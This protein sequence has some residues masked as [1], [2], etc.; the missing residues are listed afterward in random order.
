ML[1]GQ[2]RRAFLRAGFAST[3]LALS[4]CTTTEQSNT[5][6]NHSLTGSTTP[7]VTSSRSTATEDEATTEAEQSVYFVAPDGRSSNAGTES[8]PYGSVQ[9]ALEEAQPGDTVRLAPGEYNQGF[10]TVRSGRPGAPITIT[11]PESALHRQI[12]I[13]N[14][15]HIHLR[16]FT[17]NGLTNPDA[18]DDPASYETVL[19]HGR[20][21]PDSDAYL[22][23]IVCAPAGIGNAARPLMLFV[24][25]K[26]LEIGPLRVIGLAG[27]QH[28]LA[29]DVEGHAGEIVY[30]GQPPVA[31]EQDEYPWDEIDQTRN[32]HVHHIDN[33]AGHPHS[34][35]VNAKVGTRDVLVEYCTDAGGSHNTEPSPAASIRFESYDSTVRWCDLRN[36][37]GY[38]IHVQAANKR[39]LE[40]RDDPV[41]DPSVIGTG[42]EIYGNR[43]EGFHNHDLVFDF[44]T[45]DNQANICGNTIDAMYRRPP[46]ETERIDGSPD[47]ECSSSLPTGQGVG[48]TGGTN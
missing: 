21:P 19:V 35:I 29:D 40:D 22:E 46:I 38:A 2:R 16:G 31:Y 13:I 14:H 15:S 24:R 42:H 10:R 28:T 12:V 3:V 1:D 11:G 6:Q 27:A 41:V 26:N 43:V 36:G 8:S 30:L 37:D 39:W 18:P 34:E 45:P 23:D 25:T 48:H 20:P 17:I 9:R 32:V 4:G 7:P 47:K 44:T 5:P 33:S